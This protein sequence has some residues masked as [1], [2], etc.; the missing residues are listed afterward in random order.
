MDP[1]IYR[2]ASTVDYADPV[3][4]KLDVRKRA[5]EGRKQ[6]LGELTADG[7]P[8]TSA[9]LVAL[10]TGGSQ[11][12]GASLEPALTSMEPGYITRQRPSLALRSS[13]PSF[14]KPGAPWGC[15][16]QAEVKPEFEPGMSSAA[17]LK[18]RHARA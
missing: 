12:H 13:R 7:R 10:L 6:D 3:Q 17:F 8:D 11:G 16:E 5:F 14:P 15:V 2:Q 1:E 18:D 9:A 4:E